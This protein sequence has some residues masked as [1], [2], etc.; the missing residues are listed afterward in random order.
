MALHTNFLLDIEMEV[1]TPGGDLLIV[2]DTNVFLSHLNIV[3]YLLTN[4]SIPCECIN[5]VFFFVN[6]ITF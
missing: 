3:N 5:I 1:D 2:I 4:S 6:L